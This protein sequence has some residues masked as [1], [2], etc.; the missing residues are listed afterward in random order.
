MQ[1]TLH[2]KTRVLPGK[3][4]EITAPEL[5]EGESVEVLVM[6]A[7]DSSKEDLMVF[8]REAWAKRPPVTDPQAEE[9]FIL[10]EVMEH[11]HGKQPK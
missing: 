3:R 10:D 2:L 7:R 4:I 8:L 5:Q 11:R 9:E 1:A 6:P